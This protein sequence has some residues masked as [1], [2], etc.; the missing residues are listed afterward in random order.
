MS[1]S[2][3]IKIN[4]VIEGAIRYSVSL[5]EIDAT[6][7]KLA[8][9]L[10]IAGIF[11]LI[12]A[13]SLSLRFAETIIQPLIELKEFANELAHGNFSIEAKRHEYIR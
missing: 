11:I 4:N 5:N 1:I 8:L 12:I 10:I 13:I 2:V 7:F 9:G 6:I 3:P